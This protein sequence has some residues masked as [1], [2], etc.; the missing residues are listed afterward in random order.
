MTVAPAFLAP[1]AAR[2]SRGWFARTAMPGLGLTLGMTM[3][4]LW[5]LVLLPL[6]AVIIRSLGLG[7][8]HFVAVAFSARA[9][10]AYRLSFGAS[11]VAAAVNAVFGLLIAWVLVRY[12]FP[13]QAAARRAGRP[14]VRAADGGGGHRAD[15]PLRRNG[16]IGAPLAAAGHQDRLHAARHRRSR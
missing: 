5:L 2:R 9:L 1:A 6:A 16:W 11:L 8:A 7:P 14:A 4:W 15:R 10:A 13:G 3:L 12:D